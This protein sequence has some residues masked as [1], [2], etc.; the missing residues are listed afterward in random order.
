VLT[1]LQQQVATIV[2]SLPEAADFALAG[3]AALIARGDVIRGTRDLD[4][5]A[6]EPREVRELVPAVERALAE[7]GLD[8]RR[9]REGDAFFR[10]EVRSGSEMTEV[11]FGVDARLMPV[12]RSPFGPTLAGEEL[13]IDKVLAVFGRAEARDFIDLA[14]IADQYGLEE[15]CRKAMVKDRGFDPQVLYDMIGR[16]DRLDRDEFELPDP[17]YARLER[18]VARWRGLIHNLTRDD[19]ELRLEHD[20]G[21]DLGVDL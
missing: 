20:R 16:F 2:S 8:V 15:L 10:L 18:T 19:L 12:E 11:D 14:A 9:V 5:F 7:A 17:A 1:P 6:P 4:F 21:D 13:A 3:G